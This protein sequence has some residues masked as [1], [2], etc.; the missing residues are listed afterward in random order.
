MK[1]NAKN[2]ANDMLAL[3]I[4]EILNFII[5]IFWKDLHTLTLILLLVSII[6]T[7]LTYSFTQNERKEAGF[8]G[9]IIGISLIVGFVGVIARLIDIILGILVLIHS[10]NYLKEV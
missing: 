5:C 6:I 10:I 3:G 1:K 4:I 9:I 2:L 8:L 7:F